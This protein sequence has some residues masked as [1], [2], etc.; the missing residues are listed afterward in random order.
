MTVR[1]VPQALQ[2]QHRLG[3]FRHGLGASEDYRTPAV[4]LQF[5]RRRQ[6]LHVWGEAKRISG[7]RLRAR[8]ADSGLRPL[9]QPSCWG[10]DGLR[11]P[12]LDAAVRVDGR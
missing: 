5:T 8:L 2:D 1:T 6:P 10:A 12:A 11:G 3:W 4:R 7:S 9:F